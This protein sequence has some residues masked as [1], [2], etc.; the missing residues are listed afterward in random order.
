MH[1]AQVLQF[2]HL[3]LGVHLLIITFNVTGLIVIPIGVWRR[4]GW[5]RSCPWRTAH[6]LSMAVVAAQAALGRACFLTLWQGDLM[7]RAGRQGLQAGLIQT[8]I[9][10]LMFWNLPLS[11]FT[12]LYMAVGA[13]TVGLWWWAPPRCGR[14]KAQPNKTASAASKTSGQSP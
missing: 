10:H 13:Y 6:L 2:A 8:W 5:V 9:D 11:V 12:L 1:A 4:W 7:V 3:V 14:R